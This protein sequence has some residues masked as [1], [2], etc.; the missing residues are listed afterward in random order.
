MIINNKNQND[1]ISSELIN[2]YDIEYVFDNKPKNRFQTKPEIENRLPMLERLRKKISNIE[3]CELKKNASKLVFSD[4]SHFSPIMI[5]GEG[6]G[7][8]ED[9]EGKPFV[10]EA[11][12]LLNKMLKS[13]NIERKSVYIT[14]VVNYRPPE[15]RKPE[16]SEILR[17]SNFLKEHISIIDPKILILMGSTAMESLFSSNIK[18]S[19]ERGKWKEVIIKQKTYLTMITFHPAYLLRQ[20]DQ[21]KYSWSDLKEIRNK[22]NELGIKL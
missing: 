14:N 20:P 6:P 5:V 9:Q 22:I 7:Q 17:Y 19:K 16:P 3:N 21:K 13:I 1:I 12:L 18:I 4:G 2:S 11:G 10:G 15:N 8:K